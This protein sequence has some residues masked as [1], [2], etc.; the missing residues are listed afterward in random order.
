[1]FSHEFHVS[2]VDHID[3]APLVS[4]TS[5]PL[6]FSIGHLS[7]TNYA[8]QYH[9]FIWSSVEE[10]TRWHFE[11]AAEAF[12]LQML[13][14]GFMCSPTRSLLAAIKMPTY[15]HGCKRFAS[16]YVW[17]P[18]VCLTDRLHKT[19]SI[20]WSHDSPG[21]VYVCSKLHVHTNH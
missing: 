9:L 12:C 21:H 6:P 14:E 4:C 2:C 3:L 15:E 16:N 17:Q 19:V 7:F 1:M 5:S 10:G 18:T 8:C 11:P 13:R 20:D